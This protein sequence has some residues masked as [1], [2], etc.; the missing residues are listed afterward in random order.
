MVN[1]DM[2]D[3]SVG[4]CVAQ[5]AWLGPKVDGRPALL[6]IHQMN[7]MNSCNGSSVNI[8]IA[9]AIGLSAVMV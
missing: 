5:A 8:V 1:V 6:C 3:A 7:Q 4:G 2:V 9:V